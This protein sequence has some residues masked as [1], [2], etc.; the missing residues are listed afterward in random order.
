MLIIIC[1][2]DNV[3]SRDYFLELL[4]KYKERGYEVR[5][6]SFEEITNLKDLDNVFRNLFGFKQIFATENLNKRFGRKRSADLTNLLKKIDQ[7]KELI[8]LDWED[9][10]SARE[11]KLSK[12]GIVKE[13]KP[14]RNVFKLLEACYP[15]NLA[16]FSRILGEISGP[17]SEM[18]IYIMLTRHIR[19]LMLAKE[20]ESFPQLQTWQ[21]QRIFRQAKHWKRENLITFYQKLLGLDISLKTGKSPFNLRNAIEVL[22]CYYIS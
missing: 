12:I 9:S 17:R 14:Q 20:G 4:N 7:S 19:S 6:I 21:K 5:N 15:S 2:E 16:S 18:F 3:A 22:C 10:V 13:F 8:L 11:L 1:G